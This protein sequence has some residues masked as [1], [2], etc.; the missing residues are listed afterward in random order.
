MIKF[1]C[2]VPHSPLLV[3]EIGK[4]NL[5]KLSDTVKAYEYLEQELYA[6]QPDVIMLISSHAN[7]RGGG[8]FTINQSPSLKVNFKEFGDLV[9]N[10][11]YNNEIGFGYQ[12]KEL[13]E[14][15]CEV[16]MTADEVLDYGT[17][18]P[19]Y[20]MTQH[21]KD[22]NIVSIGYA[23]LPNAAHVKFGEMIRKHIDH[24]GKRVAIIASGDLS[25]KL[26]KD[27]PSGYSPRGQEFDQVIKKSLAEN[28]LDNII[29]M[30]ND[31]VIE[32]GECG[33]RS[34][35]ILLG[36]IKDIDFEI[37]HLSYQAPFGIGYLAEHFQIK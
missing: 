37:K 28:K 15:D 29:N 35:L 26:H 20:K 5:E 6:S 13:C 1:A 17:G 11:E 24:V 2:F 30:D 18:I 16:I 22:V 14:N 9:T 8:F 32:A 27:S 3:P 12:I 36:I 19:L 34:L 10:L 7:N 21:L 4:E 25:H 23:D 33:F 31:L